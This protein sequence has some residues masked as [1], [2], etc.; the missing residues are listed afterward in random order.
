MMSL[1]SSRGSFHYPH[2]LQAAASPCPFL[3]MATCS[4]MNPRTIKDDLNFL[5]CER[6]HSVTDIK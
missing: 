1:S 5:S 3:E 4:L 2:N 6:T